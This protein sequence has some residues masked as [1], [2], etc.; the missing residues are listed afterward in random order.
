MAVFDKFDADLSGLISAKEFARV[1]KYMGFNPSEEVF[2]SILRAVDADGSGEIDRDE[3]FLAMK[4]FSEMQRDEFRESFDLFERDG[5]IS[6]DDLFG[7]VMDLGWFTTE[8]TVAEAVEVVDK[9]GTGEID[10]DEFAELRL[11]LCVR[12]CVGVIDLDWG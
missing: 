8:E 1:L 7:V 11:C 5:A 2:D 9:D 6:T 10:F 4:M 12:V 3:F